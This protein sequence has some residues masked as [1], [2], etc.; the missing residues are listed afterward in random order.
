[1]LEIF[2]SLITLVKELKG[3]IQALNPSKETKLSRKI[4]QIHLILQTIIDDAFMIFGLIENAEKNIKEFGSENYS[5]IIIDNFGS[6]VR[7]IYEIG[8]ILRDPEMSTILWSFNKKSNRAI[9]NLLTRKGNAIYFV[10]DRIYGSR[11]QVDNGELYAIKGKNKI[12]AFPK[13]EEQLKLLK[14][15]EVNSN[16]LSRLILDKVQLSDLLRT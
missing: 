1:M 10:Y 3:T 6:Q 16:L 14:E 12:I 9:R 15:L 8:D 2:A 4:L 5:K 13:I 7:R 11:L